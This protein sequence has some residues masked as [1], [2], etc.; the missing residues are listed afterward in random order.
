MRVAARFFIVLYSYNKKE[1]EK[2]YMHFGND[3][4]G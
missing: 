3:F 1:N 4:I 2:Y